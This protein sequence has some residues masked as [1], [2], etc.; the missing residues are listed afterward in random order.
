MLAAISV[1]MFFIFLAIGSIPVYAETFSSDD[2][3]I[4]GFVHR[5]GGGGSTECGPTYGN[6]TTDT[7]L[8]LRYSVAYTGGADCMVV[9]IEWDLSDIPDN[10][11]IT[12]AAVKFDVVGILTSGRNCNYRAMSNRPV[13]TGSAQTLWDDVMDGNLYAAND[14]ACASA[15]DNKAVTLNVNATQDIESQLSSDWFA[16]GISAVSFDCG[17]SGNVC[18]IQI[19]SEENAAPNPK[20]TL[21]INYTIKENLLSDFNYTR[22]I[23]ISYSGSS[24]TDYQ[25]NFTMDTASLISA[26]KMRSDCADINITDSDKSTPLSYWLEGGCNTV[27]TKLWVKVPSIP[28]GGKDIHVYYGNP[29]ASANSS[30]INNTFD[31]YETFE[32]GPN[33]WADFEINVGS[34]GCDTSLYPNSNIDASTGSPLPSMHKGP[35]GSAGNDYNCWAGFN[36]TLSK[37][38]GV[39]W[40]VQ[41]S[42]RAKSATATSSV[43]NLYVQLYPG[44]IDGSSYRYSNGVVLGGTTD[45]GW[46]PYGPFENTNIASD[47]KVNLFFMTVDGW[48]AAYSK[49]IWVDNIMV[50]KVVV[51]HPSATLGSETF[52]GSSAY[53]TAGGG[54]F[55]WSWGAVSGTTLVK[56]GTPYDW[57]WEVWTPGSGR[58]TPQGT[59]YF[60]T[61]GSE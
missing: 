16:V 13:T 11:I 47:T 17:N 33:G 1:S 41:F 25:V 50:R 43:T 55:D 5:S 10:A 8:D 42:G 32:G 45:S 6:S 36:K 28:D 52:L 53:V 18:R 44:N 21:E 19:A 54:P 59:P 15:G 31:I 34:P 57:T 58:K 51:N 23:T 2:P 22:P 38:S 37:P 61:W 4:D 14:A 35:E 56:V 49:E 30:S 60:W 7:T 46:D 12:G 48:T 40:T 3:A 24:L 29:G 39:N 20:P 9:Y 26:G 27:S